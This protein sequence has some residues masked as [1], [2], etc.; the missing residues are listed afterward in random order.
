[1]PGLRAALPAALLLLSS[2][3]PAAPL[4][5]PWPLAPGVM[6]ELNPSSRQA[7][8]AAWV[9]LHYRNFNGASPNRLLALKQVLKA[10]VKII[11]HVGMKYYLQFDTTHYRSGQEAGSCFATVLYLKKSLPKVFIKCAD[12]QDQKQIQE[13]DSR[14]YQYLRQQ[15][16]PITAYDIPDSH[17]NIEHD[18]F[19][20]WTLAALGSSYVMMKKSREN[21]G[22]FLAQIKAVKQWIRKDNAVEFEFMILLH[23]TPTQEI[24]VCRMHLI[25]IFGHPLTV[26]HIC[27]SKNHQLDDGSGQESGSAAGMLHEKGGNF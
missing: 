19:P 10:T 23:E 11:P 26:K 14:F 13:E 20:V 4:Q 5:P 24:H 2:F 1:M 16:K 9:A 21:K 6:H 15:T 22:Y 18:L 12:A 8:R 17:G 27:T 25:W 3:P 7:S